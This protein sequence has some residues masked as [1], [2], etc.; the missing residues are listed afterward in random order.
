[1]HKDIVFMH[2]GCMLP[3]QL[4][5]TE[6]R[7]RIQV[8]ERTE[9]RGKEEERREGEG[10]AAGEGRRAGKGLGCPHATRSRRHVGSKQASEQLSKQAGRP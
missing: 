9:G 4:T 10:R 1:M 6:G 5:D 3:M 7:E 2:R 8:R